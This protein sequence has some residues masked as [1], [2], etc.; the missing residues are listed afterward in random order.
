MHLKSITSIFEIYVAEK[1][2]FDEIEIILEHG[3]EY[4][5]NQEADEDG[6]VSTDTNEQVAYIKRQP[7]AT[8]SEEQSEVILNLEM[9][10]LVEKAVTVQIEE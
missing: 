9:E 6:Q 7:N 3:V 5:N 4:N 8:L 2:G 10:F 1:T